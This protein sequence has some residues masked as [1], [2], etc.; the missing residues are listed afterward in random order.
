MSVS[1]RSFAS[2]RT[3]HDFST[4]PAASLSAEITA[5]REWNKPDQIFALDS[6][7]GFATYSLSGKKTIKSGKLRLNEG[8]ALKNL[9]SMLFARPFFLGTTSIC[10]LDASS[11]SISR[12]PS[13]GFEKGTYGAVYWGD[14]GESIRCLINGRPWP[15]GGEG[16]GFIRLLEI[17]KSTRQSSIRP[18]FTQVP[19]YS[20][21]MAVHGSQL[22]VAVWKSEDSGSSIYSLNAS[23]VR[24]RIEKSE[25]PLFREESREIISGIDGNT[26]LLRMNSQEFFFDNSG[27]EYAG[28]SFLVNRASLSVKKVN[29]D[30][31]SVLGNEG[32]EWLLLCKSKLKIGTF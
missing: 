13:P 19:G 15:N 17:N 10:V 30:G 26:G 18:L 7:G 11:Q 24:G 31:C 6:N 25:A 16:S 27:D 20:G 8:C 28:D 21:G 1:P 9:R 22:F 23:K 32:D 2:F 4:D 5:F 29:F 3:V 12:G 14:T